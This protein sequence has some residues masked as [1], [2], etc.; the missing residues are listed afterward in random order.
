MTAETSTHRV[1]PVNIEQPAIPVSRNPIKPKLKF[2][3]GWIPHVIT[4]LL[5]SLNI[6]LLILSYVGAADVSSNSSTSSM[7]DGLYMFVVHRPFN[8]GG[9]E[10]DDA[11]VRAIPRYGL[12][13]FQACR[14][15]MRKEDLESNGT[16]VGSEWAL[17][18]SL[19]GL[20]AGDK[21]ELS[22]YVLFCISSS[23]YE[24]VTQNQS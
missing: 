6:S 9:K 21:L 22:E 16:C 7:A 14:F 1:K 19:D 13:P 23:A 17:K 20:D 10:L 18:G 2:K 5:L 4:I 8:V 11:A 12:S 24:L 3:R 15:S